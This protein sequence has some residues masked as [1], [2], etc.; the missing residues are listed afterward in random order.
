MAGSIRRYVATVT[1][2]AALAA[3]LAGCAQE[4]DDR[5]SGVVVALPDGA[6]GAPK[7]VAATP[8]TPLAPTPTVSSAPKVTRPPSATPTPSVTPRA[9]TPAKEKPK[10]T[11]KPSTTPE[12]KPPKPPRTDILPGDRGAKVLAM[13]QRLSGLGYWLGEPDGHYGYLT[14]QAV[15]AFQ[16]S[17]GLSRDGAVGPATQKAL[18]NGVRPS[19]RLGGN[20][21]DIDLKRQILMIVRGGHVKYILN[22]STG[23]G[24]KYTQK[25]GDTATARTPKGTFKV[26]YSVDGKDEGFLGDMWRPRYFH[27]GYAVHGSPSIPPYPAS[28]G[29]A[30]VSNAAM[31]MIWA[32][33]FM[34]K[35]GTVLV[36]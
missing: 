19:T 33:D 35:G 32:Q 6:A 25:D 24:Y 23:G 3:G 18:A 16:K 29:C 9:T 28:H 5:G 15:W 11:P 31:N 12:A 36:R 8:T 26:Y 21:V 2:G 34:P 1:V 17:A 14:Q 27:G 10:A 13:Q 4:A 20:G 30:R 22:T 7:D